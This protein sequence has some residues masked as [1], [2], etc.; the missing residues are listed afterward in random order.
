MRADTLGIVTFD[1]S[2][3]LIS[4]K[5]TPPPSFESKLKL[6]SSKTLPKLG[7]QTYSRK[8]PE[9]IKFSSTL[10]IGCQLSISF[11]NIRPIST[12]V[13]SFYDSF[14]DYQLEYG[15]NDK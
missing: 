9:G 12:G 8:P 6:H 11:G 5:C 14:I 2:E 4:L 7:P 10:F 1:K 3:K 15:A 13:S